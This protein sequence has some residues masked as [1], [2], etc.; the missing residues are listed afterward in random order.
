MSPYSRCFFKT[1]KRGV[2]HCL[3]GAEPLKKRL[4]QGLGVFP[5]DGIGQQQ[6]QKLIVR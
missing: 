6:L 3:E 4:G 2:Q 5:G 1:L